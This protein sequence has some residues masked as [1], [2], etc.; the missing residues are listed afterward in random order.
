M[1]TSATKNDNSFSQ[2]SSKPFF[3]RSDEGSF[4]SPSREF[5]PPFFR[6]S[7]IQPK[8]TIEKPGDKYEQEADAVAEKVVNSPLSLKADIQTP[9]EEKEHIQT[10]PILQLH[11][12]EG[13][14][15]INI[16]KQ[17]G[18]KNEPLQTTADNDGAVPA[19]ISSSISDTKGSGSPLPHETR[20]FM[21]NRIGY[22]FEKVKIHTDSNAAKMNQIFDSHAFTNEKN[23]YFNKEKYSP[24]TTEGK[25]LLAHELTHTVQQDSLVNRVQLFR[26]TRVSGV[27]SHAMEDF[28][29]TNITST[30]AHLKNKMTDRDR[31]VRARLALVGTISPEYTTLTRLESRWSSFRRALTSTSTDPAIWASPSSSVIATAKTEERADSIALSG[32]S[33][34]FIR[35]SINEFLL[36]LDVYLSTRSKLDQER[37]EFNRFDPLINATDVITLLNA[38]PGASFT[39]ADLKALTGQ[40]TADFT[41]TRIDGISGTVGLRH[42]GRRN[43][44]HIGVGQLTPAASAEAIVWASS[45]GVTISPAPDPRK[46]PA[47][48]FKLTAAYMGRV[49]QILQASLPGNIPGGDEYKKLVFAGYNGGPGAVFNAARSFTNGRTVSYTWTQISTQPTVTGQMRNYVNDIVRRLS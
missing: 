43:A 38:I 17:E 9:P 12:G 42:Q 46:I 7:I 5:K 4:F 48:A 24:H 22:D 35:G 32:R 14:N 49:S 45:Q 47:E 44:G 18:E 34:R 13:P 31:L 15:Q 20:L 33:N 11:E 23:I 40:E 8:L 26:V 29:A 6:P 28:I 3:N 16:Q 41:N 10:K 1:K 25:K 39:R 27:P 21:E 36:A 37:T 2:H 30:W 19:N